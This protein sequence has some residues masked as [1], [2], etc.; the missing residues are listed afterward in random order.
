MCL[1]SES[2]FLFLRRAPPFS[3]YLFF[4]RRPMK[5]LG[6]GILTAGAVLLRYIFV[7][8]RWAVS[9]NSGVSISPSRENHRTRRIW[10]PEFRKRSNLVNRKL[11]SLL[12]PRPSLIDR[13]I[14]AFY[15]IR[16]SAFVFVL[17]YLSDS[18]ILQLDYIF[19]QD[20]ACD[21]LRASR[22]K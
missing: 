15:S 21:A 18:V 22:E 9:S 12:A 2:L 17:L 5:I 8:I 3:F 10:I 11:R 13:F 14:F 7:R 20:I 4:H 19:S 6:F 16:I 1:S